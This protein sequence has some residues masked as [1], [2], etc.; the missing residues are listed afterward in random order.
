MLLYDMLLICME[1][2]KLFNKHIFIIFL[3]KDLQLQLLQ[4][5]LDCDPIE[6]PRSM[7]SHNWA[8]RQALSEDQWREARPKLLD[9]LLASDRVDHC[10]CDHCHFQEA[11][12]RCKDCLPK[13]RFCSNCD[14]S[15]HQNLVFHN[16][17]SVVDWFFKALPPSAVVED[18]NG[19][20]IICEQ[21]KHYLAAN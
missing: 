15:I 20:H 17:D 14:I 8:L 5:S 19:S 3:L 16:R 2:H 4:D 10:P 9:G 21:C 1:L 13:P 18:L 7:A 6:E 11:V 12:I